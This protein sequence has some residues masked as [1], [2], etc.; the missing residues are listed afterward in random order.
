MENSF[1]KILA[2]SKQRKEL[3]KMFD[4]SLVMVYYTLNFERNGLLSRRI[5]NY[6][7]NILKCPVI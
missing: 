3:A 2:T 1:R 5:R 7:I 6:A 4:C